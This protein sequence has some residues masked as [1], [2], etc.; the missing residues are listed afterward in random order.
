MQIVDRNG[1]LRD[2][3]TDDLVRAHRIAGDTIIRV[4]GEK[5]FWKVNSQRIGM[6]DTGWTK[7]SN[8][9]IKMGE[10]DD[11][12]DAYLDDFDQ[13]MQFVE[14]LADVETFTDDVDDE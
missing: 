1:V 3:T 11:D 6:I 14:M 2:V 12:E 4:D 5:I 7:L 10:M 13:Y 8:G 9:L